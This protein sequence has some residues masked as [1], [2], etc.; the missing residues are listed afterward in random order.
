MVANLE[1]SPLSLA[2]RGSVNKIWSSLATS[3]VFIHIFIFSLRWKIRK[4]E[5]LQNEREG[6]REMYGRFENGEMEKKIAKIG[7]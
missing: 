2:P 7:S 6:N 1:W 3:F 5:K 4:K